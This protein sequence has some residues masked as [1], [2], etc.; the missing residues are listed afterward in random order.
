MNNVYQLIGLFYDKR[1]AAASIYKMNKLERYFRE[2]A[3]AG[4]DDYSQQTC[5][6][7]IASVFDYLCANQLQSFLDLN[8]LDIQEIIFCFAENDCDFALNEEK[9]NSFLDVLNDFA[10]Y[11]DKDGSEFDLTFSQIVAEARNSF[12]IKSTFSLPDREYISEQAAC[13]NKMYELEDNDM[14]NDLL[15]NMLTKISIYYQN[16]K[17]KTDLERAVFQFVG[18]VMDTQVDENFMTTFWDF[19]F[20]DYHLA[21]DGRTPI[22]NYYDE[23]KKSIPADEQQL[24]ISMVNASFTIFIIT[25]II[26]D[27]VCCQNLLTEEEFDLPYPDNDIGDYTKLLF[28]GHM[29]ANDILMLNYVT[30]T[31]ASQLLCKRIKN[32]ILNLYEIYK[33]YQQP[34]ATIQE[35]LEHHSAAVRHIIIILTTFAKLKIIGENIPTPEPLRIADDYICT[36]AR[37]EFEYVQKKLLLSDNHMKLIYQLCNDYLSIDREYDQQNNY[38]MLVAG[39]LFTFV[40]LNRFYPLN[41]LYGTFRHL[42]VKNDDVITQSYNMQKALVSYQFDPRYLSEEGFVM[43]LYADEMDDGGEEI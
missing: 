40:Y 35:F 20:F 3:W 29:Q 7:I 37:N 39:T 6:K 9:I 19:F 14:L 15:N 12:Y 31:P 5:W 11:F 4:V 38:K 42:K 27:I 32:E 28:F 23:F 10:I 25:N 18:P 8:S 41:R 36:E 34:D 33:K 22:R 43:A 24:L 21:A 30:A 26:D 16:E 1:P 17:Y 13:I 2:R